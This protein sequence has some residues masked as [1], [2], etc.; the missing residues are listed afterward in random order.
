MRNQGLAQTTSGEYQIVSS[1]VHG[2]QSLSSPNSQTGSLSSRLSHLDDKQGSRYADPG[3][4]PLS[5]EPTLQNMSGIALV[6]NFKRRVFPVRN[7]HSPTFEIRS[8]YIDRF[9][10][11]FDLLYT[12]DGC[13]MTL[14]Y[15]FVLSLLCYIFLSSI[16]RSDSRC[17]LFLFL[18]P[19]LFL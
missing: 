10:C 18:S 15:L 8:R 4:S 19:L 1:M 7:Q 12:L 5:L 6:D 17:V 2:L 14:M 11:F 13:L 16:S 3:G 9:E